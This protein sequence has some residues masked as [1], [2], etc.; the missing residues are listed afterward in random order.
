MS[1]LEDP[2]QIRRLKAAIMA[3]HAPQ[4]DVNYSTYES[5]GAS[6]GTM[7]APPQAAPAP[8][9]NSNAM[10]VDT[11][12]TG[13]LQEMIDRGEIEP[14]PEF[15]EA[16]A[17]NKRGREEIEPTFTG[18]VP[19]STAQANALANEHKLPDET[20]EMPENLTEAQAAFLRKTFAENNA[21]K[22]KVEQ[23]GQL[24]NQRLEEDS[25]EIKSTIDKDIGPWIIKALESTDDNGVLK[26]EVEAML[27]Q[28]LEKPHAIAKTITNVM[29]VGASHA[30][31]LEQCRAKDAARAEQLYQENI[32]YKKALEIIK[33][34]KYCV[35]KRKKW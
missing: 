24:E 14:L 18:L 27:Q 3:K 25:K 15:K 10:Q 4:P 16:P 19:L 5:V 7:V 1:V 6:A 12:A 17:S 13:G 22:T 29:R 31:G 21:L 8:P 9:V 11:P 35:R 2:D 23:F 26:P 20:F 30:K 32:R 34:K 33:Q 28:L